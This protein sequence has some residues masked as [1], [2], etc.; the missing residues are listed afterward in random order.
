MSIDFDSIKHAHF[1]GIGGIGISAIARMM[2]LGGKEVSGSDVSRSVI[3]NELEKLGARI[4]IG[5]QK[6]NISGD[7]DIVI[8]TTAIPKDNS[9]LIQARTLK[10]QACTYP[11]V[12]GALSQKYRTIAVSGTH[13]KTT[14]TAMLAKIFID[15]DRDPTVIVG[16]LLK[17][18]HSN[19]IAGKGSDLI[20]E[21]C[22]YRR[23]FLS[24][25]PHILIITNIDSD[26]LDYYKDLEDIQSA[27]H[28]LA[29][30][31]LEDGYIVCNPNDP[32][33]A[34]VIG[35]V[36]ARIIDYTTVKN[37]FSLTVLGRHNIAN[38]QA[39]LSVAITANITMDIAVR[40]LEAFKGTWRRC[41]YKGKMITG[42]LLYDDYAHHPTEIRATL[43]GLRERFPKN[44]LIV[45]FQPH[46]FSRTKLFLKEFAKSFKEADEVIVVPIYAAREQNDTSIN[47]EMLASE[48]KK[49]GTDAC[50]MEDVVV[51]DYLL[52]NT[53]IDTVVVIMGAGDIYEIGERLIEGI[54]R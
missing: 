36:K 46:L 35:D 23:S 53:D 48:I 51:N 19:F 25:N 22:E 14:T 39:A 28:E 38:A 18:H 26:H 12:L 54:M 29:G 37:N 52:S 10:I 27:F 47:S 2:L 9:E 17:E 43:Q 50:M 13:G 20:V 42:A 8:Y 6:K 4:V 3:T 16:S 40:A 34:P 1:I 7:I 44:E 31:V 49:V 30:K 11:Q 5:H 45:V 32:T 41:E 21:A 33:V 15:A 24:L